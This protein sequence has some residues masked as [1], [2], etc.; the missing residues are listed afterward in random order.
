MLGIRE[1][2]AQHGAACAAAAVEVA[3]APAAGLQP[4]SSAA[5][6]LAPCSEAAAAGMQRAAAAAAGDA[7]QASS[8]CRAGSGSLRDEEP[9]HLFA[10]PLE[11]NF[12]GVRYDQ[13]LVAAVQSGGMRWTSAGGGEASSS[14]SGG[15]SGGSSSGSSSS[16]GGDSGDGSTLQPLPTGRWR[17]LLDAAKGAAS[18]P[19]D[20][21]R[22]PA[23]F[24][25]LSYYKAFGWPAGGLSRGGGWRWVDNGVGVGGQWAGAFLGR[26]TRDSGVASTSPKPRG[27][28]MI[29]HLKAT[30]QAM[31]STL[32]R[33]PPHP[34]IPCTAPSC[35]GLGALLVRRDALPSL[36]RRYY[37]GGTVEVALADEPFHRWV[38]ACFMLQTLRACT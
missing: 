2:A 15:S 1:L 13:Q 31:V 14:C 20:L 37:G 11:S 17:V 9:Q 26:C 28:A 6:S 3:A 5:W 12:S 27:R 32:P 34:P 36:R 7:Q 24:V 16:G 33:K 23:D 22:W 21:A 38:L 30:R 19:P 25:A 10:L 4:D 18:C 29:A 8:S 35:A